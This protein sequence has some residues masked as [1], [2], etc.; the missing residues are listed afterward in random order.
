MNIMT[1]KEQKEMKKVK[2]DFCKRIISNNNDM[3]PLVCIY[4]GNDFFHLE[5]YEKIGQEINIKEVVNSF[6][7]AKIK[8]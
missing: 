2:C 8:H 3:E 4:E 1:K 5:C 7:K 6:E